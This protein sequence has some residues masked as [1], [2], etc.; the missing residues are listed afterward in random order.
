VS[1][2]RLN[3]TEGRRVICHF[4]RLTR[5]DDFLP[6]PVIP[7]AQV[8]AILLSS[9]P[10]SNGGEPHVTLAEDFFYVICIF[11]TMLSTEFFVEK[12]VV[13]GTLLGRVLI[14]RH[15][16]LE[17]STCHDTVNPSS[18]E[19]SCAMPSAFQQADRKTGVISTSAKGPGSP[20]RSAIGPLI[21]FGGGVLG[22][23]LA[24]AYGLRAA[25]LTWLS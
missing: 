21:G 9:N 5:L 7:T 13:P 8:A 15:L 1:Q 22:A 18:I 12:S 16:H 11:G 17:L 4:C 24:R 19:A 2:E 23:R 20:L 6:L 14:I 3:H 10:L 25:G